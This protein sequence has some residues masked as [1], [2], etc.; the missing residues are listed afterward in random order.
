MRNN[1]VVIFILVLLTACENH[2]TDT[3]EQQNIADP[4]APQALVPEV[5]IEPFMTVERG[6]IRLRMDAA[7][8][9]FFYNTKR[10]DIYR[11]HLNQDSL[12]D[13]QIYSAEDHGIESVQGMYIQDSSIYLV[14]NK[15]YMDNKA[16]KGI[17]MR[18][19]LHARGPS[20]W[21][22]LAITETYGKPKT[23]Y[24]HE[25][26]GITA[27]PDKKYIYVNSGARTDHGEVQDNN[28]LFPGLRESNLTACIFRLPA[29]G[30]DILLKDDATFLTQ[31]GYLYADGVRNAYDLEF[32]P[33]G[34]L[35][36]VSNSSDYDHSEDMFWIREG[37]HYG[38][39]WVMGNT[40]NP[41]QYPDW[42]PDPEKDP[43]VNP[44][45]HAYTQKFFAND[46]DFPPKPKDVVF[47]APVMNYG[48]DA[49][50]YR[51]RESGEV[52]DGD[53]TGQPVGTFTGHRSPLGLSFDQ[54]S[55]LVAPFRGNAF[56]LSN[57]FGENSPLMRRLSPLGADLLRMELE[58]QPKTD[59]YIVHCYR[60]ADH[61]TNPTDVLMVGNQI[62]VMEFIG[63]IWR[64][65]LPL[66]IPA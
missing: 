53:D 41:Q 42:E 25:F 66:N 38:Y 21:D 28:G 32:S 7:S 65:T 56:M 1:L 24:S 61:F 34:H 11:I 23:V 18:G 48:P 2:E 12:Y 22:T 55:I 63:K 4:D 17:V 27:S 35:F 58:Y 45:A 6:S 62:Y 60:I 54:D 39:P 44:E 52:V 51:D 50:F 13:E 3:R 36:A 37:H 31:N 10:G 57:T 33:A 49:N 46:P 59:N 26:N 29:D 16:T 20:A 19:K 15:Y 5:S 9:D 64:I 43:F 47:T 30:K 40:D 8:G 14:G